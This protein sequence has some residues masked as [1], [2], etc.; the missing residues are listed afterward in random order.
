MG[1]SSLNAF[2]ATEDLSMRSRAL[3]YL[4][5]CCAVSF[6]GWCDL[7]YQVSVEI[8]GKGGFSAANLLLDAAG[9]TVGIVVCEG[10]T[11]VVCLDLKGNRLW[12]YGMAPWLKAA[13]AVA[14]LDGDGDED[15]VAADGKGNL[16]ALSST[17]ELKWSAQL[18]AAVVDHSCPAIVDLDGDGAPEVLVGDIAGCVSCFDSS[19]KLRW[20]FMGDGTQM[21][22][23]LVADI[24][25]APGNEIIVTSH[26][27]HIYALSA[28]GEWLWDLYTPD[29]LF[30]N[31]P[32]ILADVDGDNVPELYIAGGLHHFYRIDLEK[33]EIVLAENVYLHINGAIDA[34]DLDGDG[35][36]EVVFGNKNG[37]VWCYSDGEFKWTYECRKSSFNAGPI[38]VNLDDDPALEVLFHSALGDIQVLDAGGSHLFD[39]SVACTPVATPL[40]GDLDGDGKLEMVVTS[41]GGYL[42]DGSLLLL[43]FEAPYHDDPRNRTIFGGDRAHTGQAPGAK[44]YPPLPVPK[45]TVGKGEAGFEADDEPALLS[46][47][48]TWRFDV[49]NPLA[50]R[51]ALLVSL[52]YPDGSVHT[53][54]RHVHGAAERAAISFRADSA[55]SYSYVAGLMDAD[56]LTV[57]QPAHKRLEFEGF[58]SDERYLTAVFGDIEETLGGWTTNPEVVRHF[59]NRLMALKG[60]LA[61]AGAAD[62]VDLVAYLRRSAERLRAL[63]VAGAALAPAGSFIAWE[64]NPWAHFDARD[65]LPT[66]D[67]ITERLGTSLCVGEYESLALNLTNLS[68]GTLEVRVIPGDLVGEATFPA[69]DHIELRRAVTVPTIRR[70]RV[71]DALAGLDQGGLLSVPALEAQ[72]L[73]ITVNTAGLTPGDYVAEL[74]LEGL[75]PDATEVAIPIEIHVHDLVLPRPRTI[76]FCTWAYDGGTLGTDKEHV[77]RDLVDH[78]VTVFFG[79]VPT[80]TCN[81]DG[82]IVGELDFTAHD[83]KVKRFSPHGIMLF[84]GPQGGL[85]GQPFLSGAWRKAFVTHMREWAAHMKEIGMDYDRWAL[86]IYDEPSTPFTETTI[87]TVE[88]AKLVDEADPNILIYANP[89]SGTTMKTVEMFT[90]L[91]DIWCPSSELLERLGPELIPVAKRVGKAVWFYDAAGRAKTLSCLGIYRWRFWYAWNLGL[92]GVGWWCYSSDV[93]VAWEGP[94]PNGDFFGSVYVGPGDE[95]VTSKRWEVA[96]EGI[97]DYEYLCLLRRTIQNAEKRGASGAAFE[98]AKRLLDELPKKVEATL[99][100][101]GRRLPLTPDSVPLYDQ[102]TQELADAR[103]EIIAACLGLRE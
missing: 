65:T 57:Y 101:A 55:G 98:D 18:P 52:T 43:D 28:R 84:A 96:R 82:E 85:K 100:Q 32:P 51:L 2:F 58:S 63:A 81:E 75:E 50:Q 41:L 67:D 22:P 64:F 53:S 74:R 34:T 92:T 21:G 39:T 30:P 91:V 103:A 45:A 80:A 61:G 15:I 19:G 94:N 29:D 66:P 33:H 102:T 87:N 8:A 47:P 86:Y 76:Q 10:A 6:A 5:V 9:K 54:V 14:D 7:P 60:T 49:A 1:S 12:E 13:P 44:A 25:D 42:G 70:E 93:D 37:G 95:V 17:G 4:V 99:L 38:I 59:E 3:L 36:D 89:T 16:A 88:V 73:W 23:V 90:G 26:D 48:N 24:Y 71:A 40:A 69:E 11:G 35:K 78:G 68:E 31:T 62:R 77:L 97:E 79:Q 46:G 27:Q 20:R 72:Q 83:E 56:T